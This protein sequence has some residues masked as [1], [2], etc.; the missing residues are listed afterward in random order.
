MNR[1][2][3]PHG[4][5]HAASAIRAASSAVPCNG[6]APRRP[7]CP[8]GRSHVAFPG[9]L[10]PLAL[11]VAVTLAGCTSSP[12]PAL[13]TLEPVPGAIQSAGPRLIVLRRVGVARYL[14]RSQI[15]LSA[16]N[17]RLEVLSNDWWGEPLAAMLDRVLAGELRQRLPQSQ[18][19]NE[20]G[21]ISVRPDATVEVNIRRLDQDRNRNVVLQ[22]QVAISQNSRAAPVVRGFEFTVP[23][24][25]AD[26]TSHAA[27]ASIAIGQLADGIA[28]MLAL[29]RTRS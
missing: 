12:N 3:S 29:R 14:E 19:L 23:T 26:T 5:A 11:L 18:V 9:L 13:Y 10:L 1:T 15:V 16:E 27:A 21:A 2:Q 24:Q 20:D 4:G 22:A 6:P 25:S 17:Y 7:S 28:A 8:R